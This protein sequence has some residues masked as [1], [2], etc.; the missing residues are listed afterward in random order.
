V[1][2]G[3]FV[4]V[5]L[6]SLTASER[7]VVLAQEIR[8]ILKLKRGFGGSD[9]KA[10]FRR[11]HVQPINAAY[12]QLIYQFDTQ[13]NVPRLSAS[14]LGALYLGG[15]QEQR[16]R[17]QVLRMSL[18]ADVIYIVDPFVPPYVHFGESGSPNTAPDKFILSTYQAAY[19]LVKMEPW[20]RSGVVN[21]LPNPMFLFNDYRAYVL[22]AAQEHAEKFRDDVDTK[23]DLASHSK[24]VGFYSE[25]FAWVS[26]DRLDSVIIDSLGGSEKGARAL[27]ALIRR[28]RKTR[29]DIP[30]HSIFEDLR[31]QMHIQRGGMD[32]ISAA[33]ICSQ[34]NAFPFCEHRTPL[35]LI[36]ALFENPNPTF[37]EWGP[38]ARAFNEVEIAF[39]NNVSSDFAIGLRS[40]GRLESFRTFLRA[41]WKEIDEQPG[42][43]ARSV[44]AFTDQLRTEYERAKVEWELILTDAVKLGFA[45]GGVVA[46]GALTLNL[47]SFLSGGGII[48]GA[49]EH[50]K[51]S[52]S[53]KIRNPASVLVDLKL[54][55][56]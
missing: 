19:F 34:V 47:P 2:G 17:T 9:F 14:R 41:L 32:A 18:Y 28:E 30:P 38:I 43:S 20:I 51:K 11:S 31:A 45:A 16:L 23:A 46:A 33:M 10:A 3:E 49:Y 56:H 53:F 4:S 36:N 54:S 13:L 22:S 42:S 27:A 21:I 50:W 8:N 5:D 24:D 39:L 12:D 55:A 25:L 26:D 48:L 15:V 40:D 52:K 35:R 1:P 7:W 44:M 6:G 29:F 37:E